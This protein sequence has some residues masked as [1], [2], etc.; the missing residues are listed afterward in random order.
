MKL[1][2]RLLPYLAGLAACALFLALGLVFVPYPGA[3][4]DETLFTTVIYRP[5][6]AEALMKLP[7]LGRVP[8]MLMT[9]IGS[10]KAALYVP[11]LKYLPAGHATLRVPMLLFGSVS[12]WFVF[13]ALRRLAGTKAALLASLLLATD[14][15]Y[16]LTCVFDWGPVALQHLFFTVAFYCLVRFSS[17]PRSRWLFLAALACGLALWDKALF[18]WILAGM[19]VALAALLPRQLLDVA[20][21]RRH[22]AAA[23]LGF[24][25]GA[26]P[27]LHYN[28]K[29]QWKTFAANTEVDEQNALSK[30]VML[31]RTLDGGGLFGYL[32]RD[33]AEG[34]PQN[35]KRWEQVPVRL[36]DMLGSP[37]Q[38]WQHLLLVAA[39]IAAPA[40]CWRGP[41]R[42]LALLLLLGGI[43]AYALMITTRRAGGS[44]HHTVLL[45]PLPH[46]LLGLALGALAERWPGRA[47]RAAAVLTV[48]CVLSNAAV[49]NTYLANFIACGPAISWN[50]A[51]RPLTNELGGYPGRVVFAAD[52]GILQQVEF[53]SK[54][55][56]G[57]HPASDG[58]VLSLP[59][60]LGA[61]HLE[62]ALADPQFLFITFTDG[63][64][65]FP[66]TRAKLLEFAA[67]RGYQDRLVSTVKDRHGAPTFEIHEFRK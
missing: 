38:S 59:G 62:R 17:E 23:V 67:S 27:F 42:R 21:N 13:L 10:L 57:M 51:I 63:R 2:S 29:H 58:I 45:W 12:V 18:I 32:V 60:E 33:T 61:Q 4:Y 35:L 34:P 20:R 66:N 54:G 37:R 19:G 22:A 26:A 46:L 9:Y 1:K 5:Q 52:W 36:R 7:L 50:D 64:D 28:F 44:A 53:Y 65:M 41:N 40:L 48:G 11:I 6:Q 47:W 8:S 3:Q 39:L 31:D 16:V 43:L 56:I 24:V 55:R 15:L 14:A 25:L 49:L 30:L